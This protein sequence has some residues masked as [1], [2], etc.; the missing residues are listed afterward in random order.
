MVEN[1]EE[2]KRAFDPGNLFNPGKIVNPHKMDDRS[3]MRF[4]PGYE[5]IK[6]ENEVGLVRVGWI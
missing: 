5:P 2:V 4:A 1:F 3:I 6:L